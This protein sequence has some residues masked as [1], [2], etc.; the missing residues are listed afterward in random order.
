MTIKHQSKDHWAGIDERGSIIGMKILFFV[1]RLLGRY[2]L[3]IP[4]F[5]VVFYLYLT[6]KTGRVESRR[7]LTQV[8][9]YN[10]INK[11]ASF[12]QGLKHYCSFANSAFDKIDAWLG[13]IDL[14]HIEYAGDTVFSKVVESKKGAILIG[15][16]L[17]NLEVCRALSDGRYSTPINVLTFTQ[18]AE[19][20][21]RILQSVNNRVSVNLIEVSDISPGLAISLKERVD[22]GEIIVIVGDRTSIST[23]GRVNYANFLGRSAA[24]AQGPFIL[25]SILECPVYWLFCLKEHGHYNVIFEHVADKLGVPRRNRD[26]ALQEIINVYAQRLSYYANLYP[27]QWFNF[28]DF[29]QKDEHI[30]RESK[31]SHQ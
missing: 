8:N 23:S 5:P 10:G 2:L 6:G 4:L 26:Q 15:S 18:N 21:N 28:F 20:F 13:K 16:H 22:A 7:F 1:Y 30:S 25:A 14:K 3:W 12:W 17:G 29:W 24:F 19:K 31:R 11:K 9:Q 27:Y